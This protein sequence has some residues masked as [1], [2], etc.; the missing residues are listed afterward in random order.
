MNQNA[1]DVVRRQQELFG[2]GR[3]QQAYGDL[4]TGYYNPGLFSAMAQSAGL[5]RPDDRMGFDPKKRQRN[6]EEYLRRQKH[7]FI[8]NT[9]SGLTRAMDAASFGLAFVPGGQIFSF[10]IG[11]L[12]YGMKKMNQG[13]NLREAYRREFSGSMSKKALGIDRY[14]DMNSDNI[15][16]YI[17]GEI[18]EAAAA[19]DMSE[20]DMAE[21]AMQYKNKGLFRENKFGEFSDM[22]KELVENNKKVA[23]IL[24]KSLDEASTAIADLKLRG[25]SDKGAMNFFTSVGANIKA[26][27]NSTG[28]SSKL[29]EGIALTGRQAG[30]A[31]G[32]SP[33]VSAARQVAMFG[34]VNRRNAGGKYGDEFLTYFGGEEGFA[35]SINQDMMRSTS[36]ST[37]TLL[38]LSGYKDGEFDIEKTGDIQSMR[39]RSSRGE[40]S[41]I[42][43]AD[44]RKAMF[45]NLD[46]VYQKFLN[47]ED[48]FK[49]ARGLFVSLKNKKNVQGANVYRLLTGNVGMDTETA[50]KKI[51]TL[52][53]KYYNE[54]KAEGLY[55]KKRLS[56]ISDGTGALATFS[57]RVAGRKT[58]A[59]GE[60]LRRGIESMIAYGGIDEVEAKDLSDLGKKLSKDEFDLFGTLDK[61]SLGEFEGLKPE[62]IRGAFFRRTADATTKKNFVD[63]SLEG[64]KGDELKRKRRKLE[65]MISGKWTEGHAGAIKKTLDY[66]A[67][68]EKIDVNQAGVIDYSSREKVR[69]FALGNDESSMQKLAAGLLKVKDTKSTTAITGAINATGV[70]L[71]NIL[72]AVTNLFEFGS[73]VDNSM[74]PNN[75]GRQG[76]EPNPQ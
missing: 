74:L 70:I 39:E 14:T 54:I 72:S 23:S 6:N 12:S 42:H 32:F 27:T 36:T 1:M 2:Y 41:R 58:S 57:D 7:E 53:G 21:L 47:P 61:A 22:M 59:I 76:A 15:Q 37:M 3:Y 45:K 65:S 43:R 29:I 35:Q 67:D 51:G 49:A 20:K 26:V 60:G 40:F 24:D 63:R 50:N 38:A 46:S 9:T 19:S 55:Q 31:M 71:S 25:F 8:S 75:N 4:D 56:E 48:N 44:A 33:T 30:V 52:M 10:G 66:Y 11:G 64:L 17:Q 18:K 73:D 16:K 62:E 34:A 5:Y 69:G 68:T 13:R 28:I